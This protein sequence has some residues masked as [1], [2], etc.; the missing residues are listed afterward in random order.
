MLS[1]IILVPFIFRK[2]INQLISVIACKVPPI[3][4]NV[5][6]RVP[7]TGPGQGSL[8]RVCRSAPLYDEVKDSQAGNTQTEEDKSE[9]EVQHRPEKDC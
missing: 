7:G 8:V 9:K 3:S 6:H 1:F 2:V 4:K 5:A